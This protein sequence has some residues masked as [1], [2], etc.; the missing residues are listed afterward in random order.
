VGQLPDGWRAYRRRFYKFVGPP[1]EAGCHEWTSVRH[2]FGYGILQMI[3]PSGGRQRR[4]LAHRLAWAYEHDEDPGDSLILHSCDNP[5]CV[6]P[7]HL[8]PGTHADNSADKV[9]RG[10]HRNGSMGPLTRK[11]ESL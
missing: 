3:P 6:N 4:V 5:P 1:T 11:D 9:S 2:K 10:R 7:E 8:R